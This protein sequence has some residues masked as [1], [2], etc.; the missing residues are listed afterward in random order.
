MAGYF[1]VQLTDKVNDAR[2]ALAIVDSTLPE[3]VLLGDPV[4]LSVLKAD[5]AWFVN[6]RFVD[7]DAQG[8][9]MGRAQSLVGISLISDRERVDYQAELLR[10]RNEADGLFQEA[11]RVARDGRAYQ[12]LS[13]IFQLHASAL[14]H[15]VILYQRVPELRRQAEEISAR[16]RALYE[17]AIRIEAVLGNAIGLATAYHNYA[18]DLRNI[19]SPGEAMTHARRALELEEANGLEEERQKTQLLIRLIAAALIPER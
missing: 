7:L 18:N 12:A 5:K 10:L 16:V 17:T 4:I 13:H 9:Y 2:T 19:A 1:R 11:E 3:A 6:Q 14:G 15:R 8:Y